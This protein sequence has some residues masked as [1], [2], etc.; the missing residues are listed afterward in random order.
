MHKAIKTAYLCMIPSVYNVVNIKD[1][2][3]LE[4]RQDIWPQ[5]SVV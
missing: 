4:L 2:F 1:V 5:F 3:K